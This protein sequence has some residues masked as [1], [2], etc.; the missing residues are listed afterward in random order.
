[1][2]ILWKT[3]HSRGELVAGDAASERLANCGHEE[4]IAY[5]EHLP[6]IRMV[7]ARARQ[8]RV[9]SY[10]KRERPGNNMEVV[11]SRTRTDVHHDDVTDDTYYP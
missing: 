10:I 9:C 1:V 6:H 4:L 8:L 7:V 5:S 2:D 11:D 3:L